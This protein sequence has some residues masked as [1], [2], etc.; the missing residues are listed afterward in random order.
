MRGSWNLL[1]SL[2]LPEE[3]SVVRAQEG[4]LRERERALTMAI[5]TQVHVGRAQYAY[6][7]KALETA[8]RLNGIQDRIL[9][10]ATAQANAGQES[11]QKLVREE[12]NS[13]LSQVRYDLAYADMQTAY[14]NIHSAIGLDSFAPDIKGD[15]S[16]D[17]L[18]A[19][20]RRLWEQRRDP[21]AVPEAPCTPGVD[22]AS[23]PLPPEATP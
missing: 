13:M 1:S 5:M 12:L 7:R 8:G 22:L 9:I 10:Q 23:A 17:G 4:W 16:I 11:R 18:A 14:A 20:L 6:A 2:R 15:E 21:G 19:A 3:K